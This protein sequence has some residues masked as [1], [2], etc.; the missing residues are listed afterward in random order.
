VVNLEKWLHGL[1]V[2]VLFMWVRKLYVEGDRH[3]LKRILFVLIAKLLH[4]IQEVV[5][6]CE[7][8][9]L[10]EMIDHLAALFVIIDG[11]H[12]VLLFKGGDA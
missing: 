12:T 2:T 7:E 9:M 5:L 10:F 3:E 6:L 8:L 11:L 1:A 4:D